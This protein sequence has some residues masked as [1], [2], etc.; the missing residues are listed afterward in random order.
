M[1]EKIIGI[2]VKGEIHSIEDSATAGKTESL[3]NELTTT[4]SE[5]E[6]V[7]ELVEGHSST[8]AEITTNI[9][10]TNIQEMLAKVEAQ[11]EELAEISEELP[12][13][14]ENINNTKFNGERT[15]L[16]KLDRI[17]AKGIA[18]IPTISIPLSVT[19][20]GVLLPSSDDLNS[21]RC[22][23]HFFNDCIAITR[24]E[25]I[26]RGPVPTEWD[27][28]GGLE[29]GIL[30]SYIK[31]LLKNKY[32]DRAEEIDN[33][34][35]NVIPTFSTNFDEIDKQNVIFQGEPGAECISTQQIITGGSGNNYFSFRY[36]CQYVIKVLSSG[37]YQS[38]S[39]EYNT[40]SVIRKKS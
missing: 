32:P 12:K 17:E 29:F 18:S 34:V 1:A 33:Y 23:L 30:Y 8:I 7:S 14:K 27:Y 21:F 24:V 37:T 35:D 20:T 22:S 11:E 26:R 40:F 36:N 38:S 6:A 16:F 9:G 4:Q 3:E 5:L 19:G 10:D 31:A 25:G 15:P 28:F 2:E 13:I 39:L